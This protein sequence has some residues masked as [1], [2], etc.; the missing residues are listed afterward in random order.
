[1]E[2][3]IEA[4]PG[5]V[6]RGSPGDAESRHASRAWWDAEADAYQAE[7]G[8][9]LRDVGF[10]WGPE[11][12]NEADVH[13]LGDVAG[14]RVLEVGCGAAQCS[15]WLLAEGAHP[16]GVDLSHRQLQHARDVDE[17][18]GL[19]VP[20]AQADALA[21]PFA[22]GTF[23]LACS[24][25]GAVPFVGDSAALMAEVARVLRPGARWVFAVNHPLTWVLADD[26]GPDGLV[27]RTSYFDR[28]AYVERDEAGA[29]TY[30]QHHRTLGDRVRE[31]VSAGFVLEDLVEPEWPAGHERVWGAWSPL[32]GALVPGTAVFVCRLTAG[33]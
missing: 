24:A 10:V 11:G 33:G 32:R 16:V 19:R 7:H 12:L 20:V 2:G 6:G 17:R 29:V 27:V 8:A 25:F 3:S 23:D 13:L 15:R 22:A 18:T 4:G 28:R 5:R 30:V 1:M 31:L 9:F 21:L 14:R 26:P